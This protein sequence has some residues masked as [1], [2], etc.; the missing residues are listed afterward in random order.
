VSQPRALEADVAIVGGGPTGLTLAIL[1]GQRGRSVVVIER[2]PA[3]YPLPR[4]VHFDHE[5]ARILQSAGIAP[6]LEGFTEAAPIYEWRNAK[7]EVL[8]RFGR[9]R[10]AGLSGWPDSNMCHQPRLEGALERR[11]RS[12]PNVQILR[13]FDAH[14]LYDAGDAVH[15]AARSEA[16]EHVDVRARYA[17]GCDGANSFVRGAIGAGWHDL[18]FAYDWLVVDVIPHETRVWSPLN[19]QLCD[20]ARPTTIVSGGPGRRRWEFMR[21]PHETLDELNSAETAWKLLAAW[22]ITPSNATL[23]RHAVY[24]FRARWA[25]T[26]R[27]GRV[28]LAGDAAHL[29]PPFAGQGMCS[30]M[31]DAANLAWKLDLV[32]ASEA[33]SE[34]EGRAESNRASEARSEAKPSEAKRGSL[35]SEALLDTY[36][37]ERAPHAKQTIEF[38][39]ALGR[40]ICIADPSEAKARDE[41]MIPAARAAGLTT[42]MAAPKIGPGCWVDGDAAAGELFLQARVARADGAGLFDD[43]AGSGFALVSSCGDPARVLSEE[44]RAWFASVGGVCAHVGGDAPLRDVDGAYARWFAARGC[45]VALQRPDFTVFATAKELAG[46]GR[47]VDAMR[48]GVGVGSEQGSL[49]GPKAARVGRQSDSCRSAGREVKS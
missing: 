33:R 7:G 41:R 12:F 47:L 2:F 49:E 40:V 13:G 16:G 8:L 39:V 11:A 26:W 24:T 25:D 3:P 46:A 42:P 45:E 9:E 48:D 32:L 14:V 34:A 18:G 5:I 38:S 6:D 1:L 23:D 28:L 15:V 44:Q 21:L 10:E 35:A 17:V 31:R 20:P 22:D 43:V 30:G 29:M 19:W 36:E 4:A 27:R 37:S